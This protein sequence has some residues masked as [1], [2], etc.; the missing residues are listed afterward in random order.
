MVHAAEIVYRIVNIIIIKVL[1]NTVGS[2]SILIVSSLFWVDLGIL[3]SI[4]WP[5]NQSDWIITFE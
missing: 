4:R 3:G 5:S 1:V 2:V